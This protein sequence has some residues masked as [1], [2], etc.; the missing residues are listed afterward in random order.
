MDLKKIGFK[1][2]FLNYKKDNLEF[3][4]VILEHKHIYRITDG[5]MEWL[6][7]PSGKFRYNALTRKDYPAV[8][9]WVLVKKLPDEGKAVIHEIL[10]RISCFS[11]KIAGKQVEEQIVATNVDYVFLVN[12]LNNDFNIRRLERYI[13]LAWESG[14]MPVIVLTKKDLCTDL[15]AKIA[16]V[17][18]V[19]LGVP[20]LAVN[21]LD[22][23]GIRAVSEYATEGKTV[24]LLGSSGAGKSTLLNAMLGAELQKTQEVRHGDDRG[25]HTTTHRELFFLP[26]GGMIIDTPG[27]RELQLWE[28]SE[29]ITTTFSDIEQLALECRFSDCQHEKEPGCAINSAI[30]SGKLAPDRFHSYQKLQREIAYSARKQNSAL[31][32]AEKEKW[33]KIHSQVQQHLNMKYNK[34]R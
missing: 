7:E 27:M 9:D 16:S 24:A 17:E 26:S 14:A 13:T 33:K 22:N 12:A 2:E 15:D 10:P 11:R 32:R 1:E 34:K 21:S 20:I 8:G 23:D 30:E 6:A 28:G 31:A 29:G 18:E 25:K 19:A 5:E 4:R 3:A